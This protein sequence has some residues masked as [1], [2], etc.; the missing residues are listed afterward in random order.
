MTLIN[1]RKSKN[2]SAADVASRLNISRGYYSHLENGSRNFPEDLIQRVAEIL[3]VEVK[4]VRESIADNDQAKI[5]YGNWIYKIKI[6]GKQAI[7]AFKE[8]VFLQRSNDDDVLLSNFIKFIEYNIGNSIREELDNE[9][10]VKEY[11]LK[12]LR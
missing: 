6:S 7:K 3:E 1:I 4:V 12:R 10:K 9:P 11:M 2:L 5:V 8:E